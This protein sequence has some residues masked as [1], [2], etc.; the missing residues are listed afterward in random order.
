MSPPVTQ[1]DEYERT[2]TLFGAFSPFILAFLLYVTTEAFDI[3]SQQYLLTLVLI[4]FMGITFSICL[5][6]T[7]QVRE[8]ASIR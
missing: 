2:Y 7:G 3:K 6:Q 1:R 5:V 4:S 8:T